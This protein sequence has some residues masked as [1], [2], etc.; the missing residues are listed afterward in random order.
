MVRGTHGVASGAW[1][2]EARVDALGETGHVRLGWCEAWSALLVAPR[3]VDTLL[4][5]PWRRATSAA[6]LNA[7]VGYDKHSYGYRSGGGDRVHQG[8][9]ESYG[10]PFGE[11]DVVGMYLCAG[12]A[13]T[14]AEEQVRWMRGWTCGTCP[15][16][17]IP[18]HI[19]GCVRWDGVRG[20]ARRRR[21][22]RR[23]GSP[24]AGRCI[25]GEWT[26]PGGGVRGHCRG[27][28]LCV[29]GRVNP[30]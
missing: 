21:R 28:V 3:S 29:S 15:H 17:A 20:R 14:P 6:E 26:I 24:A 8:R 27:C 22:C 18:I 4:G 11:G 30:R 13:A 7:P 19:T 25:R 16:S 10:A 9:R 1:Y 5:P 12:P 2:C 23:R